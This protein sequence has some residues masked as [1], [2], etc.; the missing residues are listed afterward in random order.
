MK[1]C[2]G[3]SAEAAYA[4]FGAPVS[5][6]G[7]AYQNASRDV[8]FAESG[9]RPATGMG[10]ASAS[11]LPSTFSRQPEDT[12]RFLQ[13]KPMTDYRSLITAYQ[14]LPQTRIVSSRFCPTPTS[15]SFAPDNSQILCK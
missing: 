3:I 12:H 5:P 8:G 9:F 14:S 13:P 2:S 10:G 15:V 4:S 11:E 7:L 1:A 6:E